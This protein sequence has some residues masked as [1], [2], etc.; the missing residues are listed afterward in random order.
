MKEHLLTVIA[1]LL[2]LAC[3]VAGLTGAGLALFFIGAAIEIGLWLRAVQTPRRDISRLLL[4][5]QARR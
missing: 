1:L 4:R 3:Y 2:G 5:I